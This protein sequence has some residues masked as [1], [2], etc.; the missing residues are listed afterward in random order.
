MCVCFG[1]RA[2]FVV[3][4]TVQFGHNI[5]QGCSRFLIAGGNK[6]RSSGE[7]GTRSGNLFLVYL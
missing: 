2:V 7:R 5:F 3:V 1:S 6:G 4:E